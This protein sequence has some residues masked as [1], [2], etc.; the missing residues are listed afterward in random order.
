MKAEVRDIDVAAPVGRRLAQV[1]GVRAMQ[2]SDI[3]AVGKLFNK[4]F[5]KRDAEASDDLK[6]YIETTFFGSPLY[7]PENGSIVYDNGDGSINSTILSV[8]ME[9]D[10]HGRRTVGRLLCAFMADGKAG[11][12]GAAC[13]ARTMRATRQDLCFSDNAS[14]VSADHWVA[15][16][17]VVLPIQSLEWQRS[18]RPLTAA[19]ILAS[20]RMPGVGSRLVAAPLAFVD[21]VLRRQRPSLKPSPVP[22]CRVRPISLAEFADSAEPMIERFAVRPVWSR[23]EFA[24]L[25]SVAAMNATLGGLQCREVIAESGRRIGIF[26]YFGRPGATANVLN[27]LCEAGREFDVTGQMFS[28][29]DNEGYALAV[30]GA[31]PFLMNAISRQRWLTFRH[32]GYFCMVTRHG[33]LKEAALR[34]DLYIGGLA[35]ESWSRLLTDF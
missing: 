8:P 31:Q 24:W 30:G 26:L 15:A 20:R 14:P 11:A 12:S 5:R 33:D 23:T 27:V 29:L 4:I 13:L 17:G 2:R 35:S 9:F 32:R 1:G 6:Q 21:R 16:G 18:F 10:V 22:A 25:A 7:S 3:P 19:V 34:N 28:Y